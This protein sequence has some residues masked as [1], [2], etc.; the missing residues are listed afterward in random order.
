MIEA[1][2][3]RDDSLFFQIGEVA[4][5]VGLSLRTIRYYE[6]IGLVVPSGRTEG[7]FRLYRVDDIKRLE[8]VKVLKPTGMALEHLVELLAIDSMEAPSAV[9]LRRLNDLVAHT[10][11]KIAKLRLKLDIATDALDALGP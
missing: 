11:A 1:H 3:P 7:G 4:E 10:Q 9:D 5:R 2:D 8:L 6:E